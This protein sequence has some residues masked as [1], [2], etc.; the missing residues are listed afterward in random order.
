[1]VVTKANVGMLE[2]EVSAGRDV[3]QD[4]SL[5]KKIG[6]I[7]GGILE[8]IGIN[9][10]QQWKLQIIAHVTKPRTTKYSVVRVQDKL[11]AIIIEI[12]PNGNKSRRLCWLISSGPQRSAIL[13]ALRAKK[14]ENKKVGDLSNKGEDPVVRSSGLS[15]DKV[16]DGRIAY[17]TADGKSVLETLQSDK[18]ALETALEWLHESCTGHD[19]RHYANE[20]HGLFDRISVPIN[21]VEKAVSWLIDECYIVEDHNALRLG[22]SGLEFLQQQ[23]V[24][25][26]DKE[27]MDSFIAALRAKQQGLEEAR[28]ILRNYDDN[29]NMLVEEMDRLREELER[30]HVA[31]EGL[32]ASKFQAEQRVLDPDTLEAE[33]CLYGLANTLG[34]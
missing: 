30:N 20:L 18:G 23:G 5:F 17:I 28:D 22:N 9:D 31:R 25:L 11:N 8:S 12:Q 1:M 24:S 26:L 21:Q 34:S 15:V 13:T 2:I 7:A 3:D 19:R 29:M 27:K 32:R 16:L 33:R 10:P 14:D 4:A 6:E